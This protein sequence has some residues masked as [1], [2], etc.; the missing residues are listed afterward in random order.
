MDEAR[1]S[2]LAD[3]LRSRRARLRPE[4]VGL[5]PGARR[6]TPGL[7]REEVAILSN[8]SATW[9]TWL[10]QGRDINPSP[11][12]LT[13]LAR[14]LLLNGTDT[15]YLFL[16]AGLMPPRSS[17]AENGVPERLLRLMHAQ[18]PAPAIVF[19]EALE[20][21]AWNAVSDA[22]YGHSEF[23]P[24]DR[25]AVWTFCAAERYRVETVD[26]ESHARRL[27]GELREAFARDPKPRIGRSLERLRAAFPE[28][29]AWLDEHE[30]ARRGAGVDLQVRHPE[31]G[32]LHME[33][34]VLHS[35]EAPGMQLVV[36]LPKAGTDTA[37]RL[38]RLARA[39]AL[40]PAAP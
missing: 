29:A 26:W 18:H 21:V 2:A 31:A 33:Q 24:D 14:A 4:D 12:I 39:R 40:A 34:I 16:L 3:F 27:L 25:N 15:D 20:I 28:A 13:A 37:A 6:R 9:Y 7:R 10:E 35:A 5:A 17:D 38:E 32:E 23:G 11:E 8:V 30:V 19:D 22:L 1:R 36:K